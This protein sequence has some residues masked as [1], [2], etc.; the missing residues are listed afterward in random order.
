[1]IKQLTVSASRPPSDVKGTGRANRQNL[2]LLGDAYYKAGDKERAREIYTRLT[3]ELT[4]PGQPDDFA[5]AGAKGLDLLD[6]ETASGGTVAIP[7]YEHLRRA[8]V[9]QFNRDF[10]DARRHYAAIIENFPESGIVPDAIFQTGR[11]YAQ[12]GNFIEAISWFERV[13]ERFPQHPVGKDALLQAA[14]AYARSGKYREAV[15]RYQRFIDT[16]KDDERIDRAHLN[17]IDVL[18]DGREETEALMWA[19]RTRETFKG[20]LPEALA[21]FSEARIYLARSDWTNALA[22][23]EKLQTMPN[24]GGASV[25]GGTNAAEVAFLRGLALEN[26]GRFQEAIE[27]YLSIPDGRNE[28]YGGRATERLRAMYAN[29]AGRTLVEAKLDSF[30]SGPPPK[31]KDVERKGLQAAIRLTDDAEKRS[32]L[33]ESLRKVYGE[34]PAYRDVP[35]FELMKLG[36]Q[37]PRRQKEPAEPLAKTKAIADELLFLGLFDEAGPEAEAAYQ[38]KDNP[39]ASAKTDLAFAIASVYNRGGRADRASAFI[40]PLWK[41]PADFQIELVPAEIT[42]MLYPTPYA[43]LLARYAPSRGVDPRY[44]LSIMRQESR[45]RPD[46]KSNAAARGLMQFISSTATRIAGELGRK[47]FL[48]DDLYDPAVAIEFGSQYLGN[49]FKLFPRQPEAV[50]ASYNGGEDNMKRL[51]ARSKSEQAE[52]YVP[53]IAFSQSKDYVYRVMAN[54]RVYQSLYDAN[55][56][57]K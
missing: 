35:R 2:V 25:P 42:A 10:T 51:M 21:L 12:E 19:G 33:L 50:A 49:L 41:L 27:L 39:L 48:Q 24:L 36:R 54:Y 26:Q 29:E 13:L 45:F 4:N 23:L 14:S 57:P 20:K 9:Y 40:E 8:S 18:R 16:Y 5:L 31:D 38:T 30:I 17:I 43:D 56:K 22:S 1:V 6:G 11:G 7:D 46:V 3:T 28:Y 34:L 15:A 32:K 55:L 47:D 44:L 37:R 52:R 53:E